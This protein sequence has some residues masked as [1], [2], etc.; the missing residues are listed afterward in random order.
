MLKSFGS[1][2]V[3]GVTARLSVQ[4]LSFAQI[5]IA[6]RFVGLTE[7]GTYAL[8][9][10]IAVIIN[11]FLFTG[12]YHALLR[13]TEYDRNRDTIFWIMAMQGVGG[14]AVMLGVGVLAGGA[15]GQTFVMLSGFPLL[16]VLTS[17][18]EANLVRSKRTRSASSYVVLGEILA[19]TTILI[20]LNAGLGVAALVL[21]RYAASISDLILTTLLVRL[22]PGLRFHRDAMVEGWATA[23]P[24][25]G[26]NAM[27][28]FSNYGADLILGAFLNPAA[29]GTYRGGARMSQ[30]VADLIMQPVELLSWSRFTRLEKQGDL[31]GLRTAWTETMTMGAACAWPILISF[32][33]LS[34]EI[35]TVV[36]AEIWGPVA[37]I[38]VIMCVSR[39]ILFLSALLEPT[40]ICRGQAR[41]QFRVRTAGAVVLLVSLL[42]FGRLSG[43][44]AAMAHVVTSSVVA[45]LSLW[46]MGRELDLRARGLIRAFLPAI[47]LTAACAG[48]IAAT[49]PLRAQMGTTPGFALTVGCLFVFWVGALA[50]GLKRGII[51]LPRS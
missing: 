42:A 40:M 44:A 32:A 17:W 33:L 3:V 27:K 48:L 34:E 15:V 49:A 23:L 50:L 7:F 28:M 1:P 5:M 13:T 38:V 26:T 30:T 31:D 19:A 10:A 16:R 6:S 41:T 45:A 29:V 12:Y 43:E 51:V 2:Y 14:A 39:S 4:I 25:W 46:F 37:A 36:F 11:T 8:A 20:G 21:G 35:V 22:R 18:N 9:W 47:V 24:L